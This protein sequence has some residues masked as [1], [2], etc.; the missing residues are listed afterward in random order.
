MRECVCV[1]ALIGLSD[2]CKDP[3]DR[4][5]KKTWSITKYVKNNE[6]AGNGGQTAKSREY[7]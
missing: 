5:V 4:M 6:V 3:T 7:C 2:A 1:N